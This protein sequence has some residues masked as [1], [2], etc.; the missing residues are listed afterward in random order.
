MNLRYAVIGLYVIVLAIPLLGCKGCAPHNHPF[1]VTMYDGKTFEI[2]AE[3]CKVA[4]S[5]EKEQLIWLCWH[6]N[7]FGGWMEFRAPYEKVGKI[8][9]LNDEHQEVK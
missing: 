8:S 9:K 1:Q 2:S 5:D 7:P 6:D 3:T 4:M